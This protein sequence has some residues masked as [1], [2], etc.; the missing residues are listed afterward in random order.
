VRAIQGDA[1]P[2]R[3]SYAIH[4]WYFNAGT[5]LLAL[6]CRALLINE[7]SRCKYQQY[8]MARR[9]LQLYPIVAKETPKHHLLLLSSRLLRR[10]HRPD[11]ILQVP[12]NTI[13]PLCDLGSLVFCCLLLVLYS[14]ELLGNILYA[15]LNV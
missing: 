5:L 6:V 13:Q 8:N 15:F 7:S 4:I 3:T 10:C 14:G 2:L 12:F 9:Q 1:L 11:E